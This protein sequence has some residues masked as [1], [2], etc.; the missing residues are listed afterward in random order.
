MFDFFGTPKHIDNHNSW[1]TPPDACRAIP[2]GPVLRQDCEQILDR[3]RW[4]HFIKLCDLVTLVKLPRFL[5]HDLLTLILQK[6]K[7]KSSKHCYVGDTAR[8]A[9]SDSFHA[10]IPC[11]YGEKMKCE[12]GLSTQRPLHMLLSCTLISNSVHFKNY[13]LRELCVEYTASPSR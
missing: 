2:E 3:N 13:L 7:K 10:I 4:L 1:K 12:P 11:E 6:K 8:T 5:N 9:G